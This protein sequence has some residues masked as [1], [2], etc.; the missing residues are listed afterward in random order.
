[1]KTILFTTVILAALA[2]STIGFGKEAKGNE[3]EMK[4]NPESLTTVS[5]KKTLIVYFSMPETT[6]PNK[7]GASGSTLKI[8]NKQSEAHDG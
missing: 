1:M 8:R 5:G 3:T 7:M 2:C 4:S 6:D